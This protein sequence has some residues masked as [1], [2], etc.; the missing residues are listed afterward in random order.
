MT[1]MNASAASDEQQR[2]PQ[3]WWMLELFSPQ[4]VPKETRRS[5][6]SMD[7]HVIDWTPGQALPWESLAPP[8]PRGTTARVW[9]H[10]VFLGVYALED[11]YQHLRR[12]FGEDAEAYD[13]RRGGESAC[14]GV[15]VDHAGKLLVD[16]S[17]LSSA[18]WAVGQIL[19]SG[20]TAVHRTDAF[21]DAAQELIDGL[22]EL[23]GQRK[24]AAD[25]P[26]PSQDADSI[27]RL[28]EIA[29][30]IAG[31]DGDEAL[32]TRRVI[33]QSD[34]VS[35]A[36]AD[37]SP[38]TDFLNSFFLEDLETVLRD[39]RAG[40]APGAAL[41]Q[42][43]TA[44]ASLRP[45]RRI[46]VVEHPEAVDEGADIARLPKGRWPS[47]PEH[48]LA[49]SQQ[50]AVN[51]AVR[52]LGGA[53]GLMGVNGPP[54]TGKTT[55]L[56]DIL[57][58]NVVERARRLADL[59]STEKAFTSV[60][61]RWKTGT[62]PYPRTVPQLQPELTGFEMV[63]ASANNAAVENV[64]TEIPARDAIHDRWQDSADYFSDIASA[65]LQGGRKRSAGDD[66]PIE[67][68]GLVAAKLGNKSNRSA[69]SA[70]FWFGRKGSGADGEAARGMNDVL[71]EWGASA[72]DRPSW[73]AA[74]ADFHR[75][76]KRVD[77]LIE[78]RLAAQ[79][80]LKSL[81]QMRRTIITLEGRIRLLK[82]G[83]PPAGERLRAAEGQA[84]EAEEA[85]ERAVG[86]LERQ[87]K[88]RPSWL[89]RVFSLG[90]ATRDWQLRSTHL[91]IKTTQIE[92][93]RDD[94]E[95]RAGRLRAEM[96]RLHRECDEARA[97]LGRLHEAIPGL[98]RQVAADR[99][100]FGRGY[101]DDDWCGDRR[102]LHAPW[103][104]EELDAARSELFLAAL[105]LHRAFLADQAVVMRKG[106]RAAM[107]VV[108]GKAPNDLASK[109]IEAA[110]QLLFL[111]V[112]MV[113][114]TFASLGRLFRGAGRESLGWLLID[115]AGQAS[116]QL[117]AG[118]I[119]RAQRVVAVGDPLQLQPVVT[120]PH[121]AQSDI[122]VEY[123]VSA[124]WM[125]P[126]ASVQTLADRISDYGTTLTQGDAEVWVSAPLT[127]HRRCD[128]PMFSLCNEI[129]YNGIMVNGVHRALD[130]PERPDLFDSPADRIVVHSYWAD[131]KE[132]P[133]GG[134]LQ[135]QQIETLKTALSYLRDKGVEAHDVI[136]VSPFRDVARRLESLTLEYPGLTAGTIHTAQGREASVVF[137]VLGGD[138]TRPGAK[139]WAA[140]SVNLVNVAVSRAKRRLYVI[141]DRESWARHHYFDR[142]ADVLEWNR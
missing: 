98:E 76:E 36:G 103:L 24:E 9:R 38:A 130:D 42:Y 18:L 123:G 32:R 104:D 82:E 31:V 57:A 54:G 84:R 73:S 56:R 83:L 50:F 95:D 68:W 105:D 70:D 139:A 115:E 11:T 29:Q 39:L 45:G 67:A 124:T 3:F 71:R 62:D 44:D 131:V 16:S 114:T 90:Q 33:I 110:W 79:K 97:A 72:S 91:I 119:W 5:S 1:F 7:R 89:V 28:R 99:T 138:P 77:R 49:L 61:H 21:T 59:D 112:P 132:E 53:C 120:V 80:R 69:F 94:A 134:H 74:R 47:N 15:L 65:V 92:H 30:S 106:L 63:V 135:E 78:L 26:A 127:V 136:A 108:V 75:V 66:D 58:G 51:R 25:S 10:T 129:A 101:P 137:M 126:Q 88:L 142:L 4:T 14:A 23:E 64:S 55:M 86:A 140:S 8:K 19:S 43:L 113:S 35:E 96:L 22:D 107:D 2:I 85:A 128:D 93:L 60:T 141:G 117:A 46:D 111:V 20:A 109:K 122:A 121:K 6:G 87:W 40:G 37:D 52:D 48:S 34:A 13:E 27:S 81:P 17:V 116:P 125:P 41:G 133:T 118:G 12:A 100:R 102:E